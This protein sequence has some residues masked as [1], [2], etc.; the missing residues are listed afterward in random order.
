MP[1]ILRRVHGFGRPRGGPGLANRAGLFLQQVEPQ[2]HVDVDGLLVVLHVHQLLRVVRVDAVLL[3]LHRPR[4]LL[5]RLQLEADAGRAVELIRVLQALLDFLLFRRRAV[6][7]T[8]AGVERRQPDGHLGDDFLEDH[9][10]H[11]VDDDARL[12]VR[13][14]RRPEPH[15]DHRGPR[16]RAGRQLARL[17]LELDFRAGRQ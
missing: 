15:F 16:G 12:A 11:A 13:V 1:R 14:R 9:Y 6:G 8:G 5:A 10:G 7:R 17:K 4:H 2:N 3:D